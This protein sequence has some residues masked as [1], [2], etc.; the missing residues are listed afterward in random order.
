M[1]IG[2]ADLL[3]VAV[4]DFVG[5]MILYGISVLVTLGIILYGI[6]VF[7]KN[8]SADGAAGI[9]SGILFLTM[10]SLSI[11][12]CLHFIYS[13][14]VQHKRGQSFSD[15]FAILAPTPILYACIYLFSVV[16]RVFSFSKMWIMLAIALTTVVFLM[17]FTG[18][19]VCTAQ[20]EKLDPK[21]DTRMA[22]FSIYTGYVP[23]AASI[24]SITIIVF[25]AR[26]KRQLQRP[27]TSGS[28]GDKT[29]TPS[30]RR[31]IR[32]FLVPKAEIEILFRNAVLIA[33]LAGP[34]TICIWI[35]GFGSFNPIYD[36]FTTLYSDAYAMAILYY[37]Y[38]VKQLARFQSHLRPPAGQLQKPP[39]QKSTNASVASED[40]RQKSTVTP[41]TGLR[42][43]SDPALTA[44]IDC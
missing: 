14:S 3:Q 38:L 11:V 2:D 28:E 42:G 9:A 29:A 8:R 6:R 44:P 13:D 40:T 23:I 31:N 36:A 25:I 4:R 21:W 15:T 33:S 22:F 24:I 37:I 20:G 26:L 39:A 16:H 35:Y 19:V 34:C 7:I 1:A 17:C 32:D 41:N 27:P 12:N 18:Y 43:K 5:A 30:W 10:T